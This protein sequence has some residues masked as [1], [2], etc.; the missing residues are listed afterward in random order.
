MDGK[1]LHKEHTTTF[2]RSEGG[3]LTG[4]FCDLRDDNTSLIAG[5][6]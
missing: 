5:C 6:G 4:K 1:E 2:L 3:L